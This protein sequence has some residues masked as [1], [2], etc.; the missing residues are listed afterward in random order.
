[1]GSAQVHRDASYCQV[2]FARR[3]QSGHYAYATRV[4]ASLTDAFEG[5]P[6]DRGYRFWL[7]N[8][9]GMTG[10]GLDHRGIGSL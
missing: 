6:D 2:V 7:R 3:R 4:N 8:V 5:G 1:M 10:S 9:N